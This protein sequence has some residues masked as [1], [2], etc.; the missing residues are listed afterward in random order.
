MD[1]VISYLR[2]PLLASTGIATVLSGVL[3]F[4]QKYVCRC[5]LNA[6]RD[7]WLGADFA[8]SVISSIPATYLPALEQ[9]SRD[10]RS[11]A[12]PTSRSL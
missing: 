7:S 2:I 6:P 5:A 1:T 11:S 12:Y 8:R 4:K 10:P 3:Y 9:M